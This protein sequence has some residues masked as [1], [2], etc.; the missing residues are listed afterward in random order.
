MEIIFATKN[1]GKAKEISEMLKGTEFTVLTMEEVGID[2]D[3]CEDGSTFE[4]NATKKAVEI[5]RLCKKPV[6]AD[7][8][9]L[10]VDALDGKPGIHS[11]RFMGADTPYTEKNKKMLELLA[12]VKQENRT[13]RFV[14]VVVAAL[15]T[16]EI[17]TTRGTLEGFIATAQSGTNGFGYDPIFYVPEYNCTLAELD[18]KEKNKISHRGKAFEQMR[19]ELGKIKLL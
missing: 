10:V 16:G 13:A 15:P 17:L 3:V 8:S 14:S 2:I 19:T 4:E 18:L 9:G 6:I 12:D 1:K 7:D 11:A 5:M